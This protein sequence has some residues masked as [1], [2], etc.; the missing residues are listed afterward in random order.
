MRALPL[1]GA[2]LVGLALCGTAAAQNTTNLYK[3]SYGYSGNSTTLYQQ[4]YGQN[5]NKRLNTPSN[6]S[7]GQAFRDGFSPRSLFERFQAPRPRS[8][9]EPLPSIPNPETDKAAYLK[10]FGIRPLR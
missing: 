9:F 8:G 3:S 1:L 5:I 6:N 2:L 7:I 4:T 10:A